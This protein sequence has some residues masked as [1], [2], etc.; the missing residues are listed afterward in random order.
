MY[1]SYDSS[2]QLPKCVKEVLVSVYTPY[3]Y[4]AHVHTYTHTYKSTHYSGYEGVSCP[5]KL[6]YRRVFL[7]YGTFLACL[8]LYMGAYDSMC[9]KL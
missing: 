3:K 6:L 7:T 5:K 8:N 4:V 1:T 9:T 2:M